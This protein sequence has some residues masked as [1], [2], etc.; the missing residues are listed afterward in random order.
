MFHSARLKLTAWYLLIIMLVSGLFS[1][2]IFTAINRELTR[3]EQ[4]QAHREEVAVKRFNQFFMK[5]RTQ[6][7]QQGVALPDFP[8]PPVFMDPESI[9]ELRWRIGLA[10]GGINVGILLVAGAAGYFLAGRTL[11]PI[12]EM[13]DEQKRFIAD[14]SHELRT[15][16]TS[17]RTEIEVNLRNKNLTFERSKRLLES[18]LEEVIS[19]QNLSNNLLTLTQYHRPYRLTDL[20]NVS[21]KEIIDDSIKRVRMLAEEKQITITKKGKNI[22]FLTDKSSLTELLVILLDNAIKYSEPQSSVSISVNQNDGLLSIT[23]KDTGQGIEKKDIPYIFDRFYQ[24]DAT[25]S[26]HKTGYGLG[27]SI[28]QIIVQS[29]Q[30]SISVASEIGKGTTFIVRLPIK[31]IS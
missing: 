12:Q 8:R 25:R 14:A 16:L 4:S 2:M 22:S 10:L 20:S 3:M 30:G 23:V 5:V 11:K 13:V 28:A 19:L 6:G 15:P 24:A 21:L 18:N 31:R 1:I 29:H 7:E 9:K 26:K 17:L 27:L